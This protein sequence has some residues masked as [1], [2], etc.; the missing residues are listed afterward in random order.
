MQ[1]PREQP[2]VGLSDIILPHLSLCV[3]Q[4]YLYLYSYWM[5]Q[6]VR[7]MVDQYMNC[8][9]IAINFLVSHITRKPPIKVSCTTVGC[10]TVE[11]LI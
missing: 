2:T 8:E 1:I 6:E 7:D 11:P 9:D 3:L 5:P 4:I 10:S